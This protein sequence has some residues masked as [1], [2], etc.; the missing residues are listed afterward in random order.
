M[1]QLIVLVDTL[2]NI[3]M[4]WYGSVILA[5]VETRLQEQHEIV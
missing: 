4:R 5:L 1:Y 3:Y 2:Y